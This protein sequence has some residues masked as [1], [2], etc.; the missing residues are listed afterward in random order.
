MLDL[1]LTDLIY[2]KEA[3]TIEEKKVKLNHKLTFWENYEKRD[4]NLSENDYSKLLSPIF[5]FE[6][7]ITFWQFWNKYP[8][9]N[10]SN[11][12]YNGE[13]IKYFFSDKKRIIAMNLFLNG[14]KPEW[15]D[16]L[17]KNGKILILDY[18]ISK[19][20]EVMKFLDIA[21]EYWMKLLC[22]FMGESLV[23]SQFI[24]GV[25]F[26]DKCKINTQNKKILFRFEIWVNKEI[27]KEKL[28]ELKD[29]LRQMFSSEYI[30]EK[31][32]K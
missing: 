6:D 12:F 15:E 22:C 7:L 10:P 8:G 4:M 11:L 3:N 16:E 18:I 25:R 1:K 20:E 5:S 29:N 21:K 14:I 13:C 24:N 26:I 30:L 27:T 17:N 19:N 23:N 31:D 9:S 32:I 2:P 28:D